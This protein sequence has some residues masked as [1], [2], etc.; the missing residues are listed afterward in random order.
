MDASVLIINVVILALILLSDLGTR[1][2]TRLRLVR[3]FIA[4]LVHWGMTTHVTADALTDALTFFSVAMML[5][6]TGSL[7]V[8]A[9]TTTGTTGAATQE[10]VYA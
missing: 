5:G 8:R 3:P 6:R 9:R 2:I 1:S 10:R 4:G 7:A